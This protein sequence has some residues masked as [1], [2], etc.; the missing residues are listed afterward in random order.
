[1]EAHDPH[2]TGCEH[3]CPWRR[4]P[5]GAPYC[6]TCDDHSEAL[7]IIEE[8]ARTRGAE[9]GRAAGSWV[10]DGNTSDQTTRAILQGIEDGDPAVLDAFPSAPLS[11]EFAD[12]LLPRDVLG[13]Y[14][15]TEDDDA[16]DAILTAYEDG[17]SSGVVEEVER[18][19]R[20]VL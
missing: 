5:L 17:F 2:C 16:A 20:A 18:S 1:M 9:D 14:G 19:A 12:G 15:M 11:G 6:Q 7:G 8:D 13:W 10:I 4:N 3:D